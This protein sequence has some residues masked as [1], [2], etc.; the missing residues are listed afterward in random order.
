VAAA[1]PTHPVTC[2]LTDWPQVWQLKVALEH[3]QH[4]A[5]CS[6]IQQLHSKAHAPWHD[7]NLTRGHL[8]QPHLC[9]QPQATCSQQR[10]KQGHAGSARGGLR[11]GPGASRDA[12]TLLRNNEHVPVS[13]SKAAVRHVCVG[14]VDVDGVPLLLLR[15]AAHRAGK[16]VS[17][18]RKEGNPSG[19]VADCHKQA[20]RSRLPTCQLRTW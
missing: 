6:S 17:V 9:F 15:T 5:A 13:V 3:F 7:Q 16:R 1:P 18:E 20:P 8:Q 4:V 2:V 12:L 19:H 11:E 10:S 14:C